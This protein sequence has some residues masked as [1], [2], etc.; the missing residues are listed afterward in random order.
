[1]LFLCAVC[2]GFV[3]R[4]T[5]GGRLGSDGGVLIAK[6]MVL[7][8]GIGGLDSFCI[9]AV[10]GEL[11]MMVDDD[12][13]FFSLGGLGGATDAGLLAGGTSFVVVV[14]VGEERGRQNSLPRKR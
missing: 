6:N 10:V 3:L 12:A 14:V 4:R 8:S 11:E 5:T 2:C 1:M 7:G 13:P 9:A